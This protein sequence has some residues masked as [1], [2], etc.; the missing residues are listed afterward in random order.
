MP[1]FSSSCHCQ[2]GPWLVPS[3]AFQSIATPFLQGTFK[4][5]HDTGKDLIYVHVFPRVQ[6]KEAQDDGLRLGGLDLCTPSTK[7][8]GTHGSAFCPL[9][10]NP[11][12]DGRTWRLAMH[13][14]QLAPTAIAW[15][16]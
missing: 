13:C 11:E 5:Q 12:E 9:E 8:H 14:G 15:R 3:G 2:V 1:G 7:F 10:K 4:Y 16:L 6:I